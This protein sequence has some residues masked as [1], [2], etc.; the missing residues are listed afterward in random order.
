[1]FGTKPD[2][3]WE[4]EK[5]TQFRYV[6]KINEQNEHESSD[7]AHAFSVKVILISSYILKCNITCISSFM[8]VWQNTNGHFC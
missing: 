2:K 3:R 7:I 6:I 8:Q 4:G 1:M 5:K